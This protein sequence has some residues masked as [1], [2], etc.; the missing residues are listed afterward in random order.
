MSTTN[1]YKIS[2]IY[3]NEYSSWRD[4]KNLNTAKRQEYLRRNPDAISDYD[5]QR[6]RVLLY[7]VDIMDKSLKEN[8]NKI[9]V[10]FETATNL[11]LGYAA[12]GGAGLGFLATK[13][14]FVKKHIDKLTKNYPKSKDYIPMATSVVGGILGILAAYPVYKFLSGM[15][16]KI[17]RKRK[18]ETMENELKDPN[19]F[20]VLN[21][22]QKKIFEQN[23]PEVDKSLVKYTPQK[24]L[25]KEIESFKQVSKET[26]YYDKEQ[27]K[28][29]EK[30]KEDESLY[31]K[32][33][34]EKEI[35]NAKKDMVLLNVLIKEINTKSQSYTEKMQRITDNLI[36]T[37]FALGSLF[38]LGYERLAK[39]MNFKS[40]SLPAGLGVLMLVSST[41]FANWA[42]RRASHVGRFKAIQEMKQN[43][44]QL[45]YISKRKTNTIEDEEI[46][47]EGKQKTNIFEFMKNFFKYNKEY[48][49]WKRTRNYTGEDISKAMEKVD[50]SPEQLRDGK[51]LQKNLF[52]TLYKVDK[53]T[54]KYSSDI[55]VMGESVKYPTT[56][57]LGTVGSVWG[58]KH[59]A[60]LRNAIKPS[61]IFKHSAKYIGT[62]A[63]FTIP[64]LFINSYFAKA[65][66]MAARI[67]DMKTMKE[68]EDY[69]FFADYSSE[70][71]D[72]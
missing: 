60:N 57:I 55:D 40:S 36:T 56:L 63:L 62:I 46:Q 4:D 9:G 58:M 30:Y 47:L 43:P 26:I 25:K 32:P 38:T 33:L 5:L 66:K 61:E 22:E 8:S 27:A 41:F 72:V 68:L 3:K 23:L 10:A 2:Q 59:L 14:K 45:V 15:E 34:S 50:I 21:D 7:T 17:H 52:K 44:E 54:Q 71:K 64:S 24:S 31:E 29:K 28:F 51:R 20:V 42:Q 16:S 35:K 49:T 37:S 12:I 13:I 39:K 65:Q 70:T 11:G 19:I 6:A 48:E 1:S 53:N 18:F 69:R 67:S